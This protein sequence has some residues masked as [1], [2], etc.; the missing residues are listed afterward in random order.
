VLYRTELKF[1]VCISLVKPS[2]GAKASN[3]LDVVG[4]FVSHLAMTNI[5]TLAASGHYVQTYTEPFLPHEEE[6]YNK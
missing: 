5:T 6:V 2:S 4:Y 3:L 1:W